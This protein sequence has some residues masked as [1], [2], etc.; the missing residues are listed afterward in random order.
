MKKRI[1][2]TLLLL[3]L[4]FL[5]TSCFLFVY[6]DPSLAND[7]SFILEETS[8]RVGDNIKIVYDVM[9]PCCYNPDYD[10]LSFFSECQFYGLCATGTD[11]V[12]LE[13]YQ[14]YKVS[15]HHFNNT[16]YTFTVPPKAVA[17]CIRGKI[18]MIK[19]PEILTYSKAGNKVT[20][21]SEKAFST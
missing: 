18:L 20:V 13:S 16:E 10:E 5:V 15:A 11:N 21:T 14:T 12:L 2:T 19:Y 4:S 7:D 17:S 8:A 1:I 9:N 6:D 3:N